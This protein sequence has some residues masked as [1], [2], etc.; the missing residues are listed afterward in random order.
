MLI[1]ILSELYSSL[2]KISPSGND[3]YACLIIFVQASSTAN[4]IFS[5][6]SVDIPALD[7]LL[8]IKS[9]IKERFSVRL[10]TISSLI[11]FLLVPNSVTLTKFIYRF[12]LRFE[13]F[14]QQ[15]K[16]K[17]VENVVNLITHICQ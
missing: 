9:R 4:I 16:T 13:Y 1:I 11:F 12:I 14:I 15:R 17:Q 2:M 10:L 5:I 3:L 6:S 7:A 8:L